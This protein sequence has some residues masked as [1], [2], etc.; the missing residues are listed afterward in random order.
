MAQ[1]QQRHGGLNAKQ[2]RRQRI[3]SRVARQQ[4]RRAKQQARFTEPNTPRSAM[5]T[6]RAQALS[7]FRPLERQIAS[8]IQGSKKREGDLGSWY[9]QLAA[10][11]RQGGDRA[12][13]AFGTAEQATNARLGEES[14]RAQD[15]LK[16][17]ASSD[18]AFASLV[19][20][21]TNVKGLGQMAEA[22][23][24]AERQRSTLQAP[25]TATRANFI[26][27]Y[28]G[29]QNAAGLQGIE[30][31][32]GERER[33]RKQQQDL[34]NLKRERGSS[35]IKNLQVLRE[36]DQDYRTQQAVT[37]SDE[38]YNQALNLQSK[39]GYKG[40][41]KQAAIEAQATKIL[42]NAKK[43]GASAQEEVARLQKEGKFEMADALRDQANINAKANKKDPGGYTVKEAKSFLREKFGKRSVAA[44]QAIDYLVNRGVDYDMAVKT[45]RQMARR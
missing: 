14:Q 41:I 8:E 26:A 5:K 35:T 15:T 24:A 9:D 19:G 32:Q 29:R 2:R 40:R 28:A 25:I 13:A 34:G 20:G 30:A 7:E 44:Q 10:T 36:Q 23:A 1:Q 18:K 12:L 42:A 21:P 33:R 45:V 31:R 27:S 6:A 38:G 4:Q 37:K 39:L 11:I 22:G 17:L 3:Q 16:G 43:R